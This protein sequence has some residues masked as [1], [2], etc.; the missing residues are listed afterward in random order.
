MGQMS[1]GHDLQKPRISAV[2]CTYRRPDTLPEAIESLQTQSLPRDYYEIIVVDNNSQDATSETVRQYVQDDRPIVRYVLETRQGLSY[3]R[4][5]GVKLA[6]ADIIAFLD[7]DAVAH[8]DWLATLLEVYDSS[9]AAWAVGGK[10]LPIW[11]G[12]RPDWVRNSMLRSLSIVDWGDETRTLNWPERM[13][14]TNCSFR[15]Q[16]FSEVGL[17][18]TNLGRRGTLLLGHED[19][20]IQERIH[21]LGKLVFYTPR[22]I[23]YHH[24]LRERLTKRY[25]YCRYYGAG[26]SQA[27]VAHLRGGDGAV[28]RQAIR[29]GIKLPYQWLGLLHSIKKE[30]SRFQF[31]QDQAY[32]FGF[33]YQA[34]HMLILGKD[35]VDSAM[36]S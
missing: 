17:F 13:I 31:V 11:D 1:T 9:P 15:K 28:R 23:V 16:V 34:I 19:T 24:I 22:A 4:N 32:R 6:S 7:D 8:P 36:I 27:I 3:S 2:I 33:L 20:E 21:V 35:R 29:I 14:G 10:I 26:R 5:T 18:A 30:E 25:F 12:E